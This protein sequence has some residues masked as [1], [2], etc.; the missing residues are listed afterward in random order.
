M[1]EDAP[2]RKQRPPCEWIARDD[3]GRPR[4]EHGWAYKSGAFWRCPMKRRET[5]R[6]YAQTERAKALKKRW[7]HSPEGRA[8]KARYDQT[9][10]RSST[11]WLRRLGRVD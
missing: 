9:P 8:S 3:E 2:P 4:C 10:A 6:R 1:T 11:A 7:N 5:V